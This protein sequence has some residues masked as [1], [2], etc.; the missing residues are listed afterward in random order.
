MKYELTKDLETGNLT[1]DREH[2]E[3]FNAVNDMMDAWFQGKGK[4]SD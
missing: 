1:I 2:K 3:L 4:N